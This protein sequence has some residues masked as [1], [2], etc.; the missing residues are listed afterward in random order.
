VKGS[1]VLL[2]ELADNKDILIGKLSII[3][4][5]KAF[6]AYV[7]S[8]MN[9]F[10]ARLA[11]HLRQEKKPHWHIDYLLS[12]SDLVNIILCPSKPFTS[13]HSESFALCHSKRSE[14]SHLS[15]DKLRVECLLA[16]ELAKDFQFIPGFGCSDCRCKSHLYFAHDKDKLASK[17]IEVA[18]QAGLISCHCEPK[19]WQSH[20]LGG[21]ENGTGI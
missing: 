3:R 4:F 14:E 1:Y 7:G 18:N 21:K 2:I 17:V 10:E 11:H 6:Y 15:Q 12:Q 8:A 9:G 20:S 19:A 16:Q 13:S 5:P